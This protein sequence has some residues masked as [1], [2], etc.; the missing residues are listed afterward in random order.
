MCALRIRWVAL[1]AAGMLVA[2][3]GVAH[4]QAVAPPA[5]GA[6]GSSV[7]FFVIRRSWHTDIGF[8][9]ADLRPPL[10]ALRSA[11]PR[12]HYL[13]FGF[14]DKHYLMTH[15]RG[16]GRLLGALWPGEG[17]VLLTGLEATPEAVFG[18]TSMVRLT[19]NATQTQALEQFVWRTFATDQG[20]AKVLAPG[21]YDDSLYYASAIRYS[22]LYTCN[23]WTA[24]A[25]RAT[26]LPV[27]TFGVELSSQVWRQVRRLARAPPPSTQVR[28]AH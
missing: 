4:K 8:D 9:V 21:P 14:G 3:A 15:D 22:G 7:T 6:P 11:L 18:A 16:I 13:L 19:V 2:C 28:T 12:A 10:A 1:A 20:K 5:T 17:L 27:H 25:L 26:G 24:E 23:T